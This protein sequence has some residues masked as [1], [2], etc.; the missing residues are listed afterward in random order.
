MAAKKQK[1]E[2]HGH[3][4]HPGIGFDMNWQ[5]TEWG[6][7]KCR[8]HY[9]VLAMNPI[10]GMDVFGPFLSNGD[11]NNWIDSHG[12]EVLMYESVRGVRNTSMHVVRLN[13][14]WSNA[15]Q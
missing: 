4:L 1:N 9:V 8:E 7:H 15:R 5:P 6:G 11:A 13:V 10:E 14:P 12:T 3:V 2:G